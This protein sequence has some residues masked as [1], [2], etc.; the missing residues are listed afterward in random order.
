MIV[1]GVDEAGRGPL[2][3]SVVAGAVVL[4][5]SF[6]LPELTDS[7]K[8]SE[9]KRESLYALITQ[10]CQW[11]V[12]QSSAQ[13]IDEIN[14]LQATMLAMKRA[15]ENLGLKYDQVLVDGNRCPDLHH[16]TAII[17]GDL[18]EPVISAASIIAKVTRDR[19]MQ[20]LDRQHPQY[21]FAKHKGYGTK[22]HLA[23]LK[24]HGAIKAEHRFSFAPIKRLS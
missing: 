10:Q 16:C 5:P 19:Q 6:D 13:E 1:V 20:A 14:I 15:V 8:L 4:P 17:K 9:K 24:Q 7:K 11:A 12:G 21:G 22:I 23:A 18:T 2:V 3:G